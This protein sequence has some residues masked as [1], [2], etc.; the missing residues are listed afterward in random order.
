MSR[1]SAILSLVLL[2]TPC[3]GAEAAAPLPEDG[4]PQLRGI[5]NQIGTKSPSIMAEEQ[6]I[7]EGEAALKAASSGRNPHVNSFARLQ[8]QYETR[9]NSHSDSNDNFNFGPYAS[10]YANLPLY[11]WGEFKAR[12]DQAQGRIDS[13]TGWTGMRILQLRQDLRR[14][15]VDYQLALKGEEIAKESIAYAR[16]KEEGLKTLVDNGQAPRQNLVEAR[17]FAQERAEE[18]ADAVSRAGYDLD[19]IREMCGQG[20]LEISPEQIPDIEPMDAS[21]LDRMTR[22]AAAAI[23]PEVASLEGE[24]QTEEAFFRELGSRNRPKIDVVVSSNVD[25]VDEYRPDGTYGTVP[26]VY[27]WAGIQA[28]WTIYD[29]GTNNAEQL[30]S[31]ARQR[32]IQARITEARLRQ[33]REVSSAAREARLNAERL[34]TRRARVKML[35]ESVDLMELQMSQ[36]LISANDLFQRKLDLQR[37]RL[38]LL[39]ACASYMLAVARL[40]DMAKTH[41]QR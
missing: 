22:A 16:K 29:G 27:N 26:R 40:D 18:L 1:L 19:L 5:L 17:I 2:L 12:E 33:S 34:L 37:T 28:N 13:A 8:G 24:L 31:M 39:Q 25:Y 36:N 38:D 23:S 6:R 15:Y 14:Y 11:H 20:G 3:A 41:F 7:E 9:I 21:E 30:A 4:F 10:V 32:R 35:E